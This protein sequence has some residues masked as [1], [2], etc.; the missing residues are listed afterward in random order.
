MPA[1][2]LPLLEMPIT[3]CMRN[4]MV[5]GGAGCALRVEGIYGPKARVHEGLPILLI[6]LTL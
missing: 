5:A 1:P 4:T 2:T 3:V 6:A